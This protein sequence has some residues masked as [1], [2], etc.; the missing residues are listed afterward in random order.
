MCVYIYI[1]RE[2]DTHVYTYILKQDSTTRLLKSWE[3]TARAAGADPGARDND[4]SGQHLSVMYLYTYV[5]VYIY[6]YVYICVHRYIYIYI[7]I[8]MKVFRPIAALKTTIIITDR[9]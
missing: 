9:C 7:Y 1:E 3:P 6:I 2:R 8:Y 4:N 5:Y